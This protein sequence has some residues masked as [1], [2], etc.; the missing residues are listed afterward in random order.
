G[1]AAVLRWPHGR[2]GGGS[3]GRVRGHGPPRL[4]AGQGLALQASEA[5][6]KLRGL[7]RRRLAFP[8][9][10]G[11]WRERFFPP[12]TQSPLGV[13]QE[14]TNEEGPRV[15]P[16]RVRRGESIVEP[17]RSALPGCRQEGRRY[18]AMRCQGRAWA[19]WF[20]CA[21]SGALVAGSSAYAQQ[22]ELARDP[23]T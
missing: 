2:G 10:Q 23:G 8:A 11:R 18:R 13:S 4:G 22:E 9:F 15:E 6:R 21:V 7:P 5:G 3:R 12:A 16:C 19:S 1:R 17:R 14:G 20:L